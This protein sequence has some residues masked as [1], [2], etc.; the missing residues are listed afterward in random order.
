MKTKLISF[1]VFL[2]SCALVFSSSAE[3]KVNGF[4]GQL[5]FEG[6]SVDG[7]YGIFSYSLPEKLLRT[8]L[9]ERNNGVTEGVVRSPEWIPGTNFDEFLYTA[10]DE[11]NNQFY[12][13]KYRI[14]SKS[15]ETM[16]GEE[17]ASYYDPVFSNNGRLVALNKRIGGEEYIIVYSGDLDKKI[18]EFKIA[19]A[20]SAS[21]LSWSHDDQF[22]SKVLGREVL[23][24][25]LS[26]GRKR[27]LEIDALH[28]SFSPTQNIGAFISENYDLSIIDL[29]SDEVKKTK[30]RNAYSFVWSPDG[31]SIVFVKPNDKSFYDWIRNI[32]ISGR[33]KSKHTIGIVSMGD[34]KVENLFEF[35]LVEPKMSW[36]GN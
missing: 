36:V 33:I 28:F 5:L 7:R 29:N 3:E 9:H 1:V 15:G 11:K 2:V 34:F 25:D 27:N 8:I 26:T 23:I 30:I 4:G 31:R 13:V 10:W 21:Y 18:R 35:G 32:F 22:V 14:S 24:Y 6:Q 19:I 12:I 17:G 16:L 20:D